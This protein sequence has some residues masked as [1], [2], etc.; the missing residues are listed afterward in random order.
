MGRRVLALMIALTDIAHLHGLQETRCEER[1]PEGTLP[2]ARL[3][4]APGDKGGRGQMTSLPL[5]CHLGP[6]LLRASPPISQNG[7][8][9]E[10]TQQP[11]SGRR[12]KL[13]GAYT[14]ADL[15]TFRES[16]A[17]RFV[18]GHQMGM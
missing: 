3:Q 14:S 6:R 5:A 10:T 9:A 15:G 7:T 11:R 16:H 17:P 13:S 12:Q 1:E 4:R 8:A 2:P 18:S